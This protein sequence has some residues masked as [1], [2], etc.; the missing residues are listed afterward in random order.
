MIILFYTLAGTTL[1]A[2]L[3]TIVKSNIYDIR[4]AK[5]RRLQKIHPHARQLR[6]RPLVSLVVYADNDEANIAACLDSLI[7]NSYKKTELIVVDNASGDNTAKIIRQHLKR[8]PKQNIRLVAKRSAGS[9]SQAIIQASKYATGEILAVLDANTIVDKQALKSAVIQFLQTG[10]QIVLF[11]VRATHQYRLLGLA[12]N[13]KHLLAGRIKKAGGF[14]VPGLDSRN[15]A[16]LYTRQAFHLVS[17]ANPQVLDDINLLKRQAVK[18][19]YASQAIIEIVASPSKI[20]LTFASSRNPV[21]KALQTARSLLGLIEPVLA[22][23][24][25]YVAFRFNNPC[26]LLLVWLSFTFLFVLTIWS[27]ETLGIIAK[28]RLSFLSL[29]VYS[30]YLLRL[31]TTY[32][33]LLKFTLK[34]AR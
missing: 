33:T 2:G 29:V 8:H 5:L 23:F 10:Q 7:S 25:I 27:D 21:A 22:G 14:L 32:P 34:F 12:D 20:Q 6:Q 24:M 4:Q 17:T 3:I 26:Y 16:A 9:R 28:L 15:F 11:N 1:T 18:S 13:L 30:L 31:V 19:H